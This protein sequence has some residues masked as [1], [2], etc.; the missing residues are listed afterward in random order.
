MKPCRQM[1]RDRQTDKKADRK[2]PD[3]P[4]KV[5]S[6]C[7]MSVAASHILGQ[8]GRE[9]V[10]KEEVRKRLAVWAKYNTLIEQACM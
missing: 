6:R 7:D 9:D 4:V 5:S 1:Q 10:G 3:M 8:K 2:K